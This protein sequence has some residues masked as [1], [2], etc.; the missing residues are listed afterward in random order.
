MH[1]TMYLIQRTW[2]QGKLTLKVLLVLKD[3]GH[4]RPETKIKPVSSV[5][6]LGL[7][8]AKAGLNIMRDHS[9]FSDLTPMFV[10]SRDTLMTMFGKRSLPNQQRFNIFTIQYLLSNPA[11]YKDFLDVIPEADRKT[12]HDIRKHV[13]TGEL[14][15]TKTSTGDFVSVFDSEVIEPNLARMIED[16]REQEDENGMK[17]KDVFPVL[18]LV[19][20]KVKSDNE[21]PSWVT[22]NNTQKFKERMGQEMPA[23]IQQMLNDGN[24]E[25]QKIAKYMF[26]Y[27]YLG[28]GITTPL[29]IGHLLPQEFLFLID[30]FADTLSQALDNHNQEIKAL[31]REIRKAP[32]N[33]NKPKWFRQFDKEL[34]KINKAASA[35]QLALYTHALQNNPFEADQHDYNEGEHFE[36]TKN[37]NIVK[38]LKNGKI[39]NKRGDSE[40][41]K[42][43]IETIPDPDFEGEYIYNLYVINPDYNTYT[44][45]NRAGS[46]NYSEFNYGNRTS[47]TLL[48]NNSLRDIE[49]QD[50]TMDEVEEVTMESGS[51]VLADESSLTPIRMDKEN[52]LGNVFQSVFLGPTSRNIDQFSQ[53]PVEEREISALAAAIFPLIPGNTKLIPYSKKT[54]N[55][56]FNPREPGMMTVNGRD[57]FGSFTAFRPNVADGLVELAYEYMD[58][59]KGDKL[60]FKKALL[61][62]STH[63]AIDNV[64]R[65]MEKVESGKIKRGEAAEIL[66][67]DREFN[68]DGLIAAVEDMMVSYKKLKELVEFL[69]NNPVAKKA[70]VKAS[71]G[72]KE[73]DALYKYSVIMSSVDEFTARLFDDKS[74]RDALNEVPYKKESMFDRIL[75]FLKEIL[76]LKKGSAAYDAFGNIFELLE[77][78]R[79]SKVPVEGYS[80]KDMDRMFSANPPVDK[81]ALLDLRAMYKGVSNFDSEYASP[82]ELKLY[83]RL[84]KEGKIIC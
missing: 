81:K 73:A 15:I 58:T 13:F 64:Y 1:I 55:K 31:R 67:L 35:H 12:A 82:E 75:K 7:A 37:P 27:Y 68:E 71:S 78:I 44:R 43:F 25:I 32:A 59:A 74:L 45:V 49:K 26:L 11:L 52:D 17:Y 29:S 76:G 66:K 53:N 84:V 69:K 2:V 28:S 63:A 14:K 54:A 50:N 57:S 83:D 33:Y 10:H 77:P 18:Q 65:V 4:G 61:H 38:L 24:P 21:S 80:V 70:F 40:N 46:S 8:A 6:Q 72:M 56:Q 42:S 5:H 41:P 16:I 9:L 79:T 62:E 47:P 22:N 51:K 34:V 39:E 60:I 23:N 19:R 30:G 36:K 3:L 48:L 20:T